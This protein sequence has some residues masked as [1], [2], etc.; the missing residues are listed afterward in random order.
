MSKDNLPPLVS[1]IFS[2]GRTKLEA[3]LAHPI[4]FPLP[5]L[6]KKTEAPSYYKQ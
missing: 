4:R 3:A 5:P 1:Y 2:P 6:P